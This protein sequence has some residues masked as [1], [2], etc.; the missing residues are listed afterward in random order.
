MTDAT[1]PAITND[2]PDPDHDPSATRPNPPTPARRFTPARVIALALIA[3]LVCGLTYVWASSGPDRLSVPAHAKAGDLA[4]HA[5]QYDTEDGSAAADCGTLVVPENRNDPHSR[6]IAVP[7]TRIRAR[8]PSPG[9]PIF[10]LQGGPGLTNM[11]FAEAS[12][13]DDHHDVVLV[14]YR[15]VDGSSVLDCP[16]VTSA[17][18]HS[19]DFLATSS[20][21]AYAD[22]FRA[23]SNRL[24]RGGVDLA[25]Y[26]VPER[27]DDLEAARV[28]LGYGRIDL[29][30]ESAGTRTAMVYSWRHPDSINRS[31]M[32]GANPPGNFLWNPSA[33]DEQLARYADVCAKD[34][35]CRNRTSDLTASAQQAMSSIPDRWG[36]FPIK[37]GNV[38]IAS[39]YG[40]FDASSN[41]SPIAAPMTI[42][43]WLSALKGDPSGYWMSSLAADVT[44]PN[45]FVWGDLAAISRA[46]ASAAAERFSTHQDAGVLG[47]PGTRF[48]WA[49]G[50][51]V[52]AWPAG[53]DDNAYS[54][55]TTSSTETLVIGGELDAT[56]PPQIATRELMPH[57][58]NGHQ[59][60]LKGFG[61]TT[62]FWT[63][64]TAAGSRL[65]NTFFDTGRVDDS[66]YQP[67]IVDFRPGM[68]QSAIAKIVAGSL[69]AMAA[70]TLL[71]LAVMAWRV[72][73][74]GRFGRKAGAVVRSVWAAA[75][76]LGGWVIGVLVGGDPLARPADRRPAARGPLGRAAR[77]PRR[78][79]RV[80]PPGLD[81]S[82]APHRLGRRHGRLVGRCLA[83]LPRHV[84]GG[85]HRDRHGRGRRRR[86]P[87]PDP[88]R[89]GPGRSGA[90]GLG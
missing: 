36:V 78:L 10:R 39:F 69:A 75:L 11:T 38:Q 53:P 15:G 18:K 76:G 31:V 21:Q 65:V 74:K 19:T 84:P 49:G 35:S 51:L 45:A 5:C 16:E 23:C 32:V 81:G 44:F 29:L 50:R 64:Q 67:G 89:H 37:R 26:S 40:L 22:A 82:H 41:A 70:F 55:V 43:S 62:D 73:R 2:N 13:Y 6:L 25:G 7:V 24:Q 20:Q 27:V 60:V 3:A 12:R 30:S 46:D 57:L 66:L 14:G 28:A 9:E 63:Q 56:T 85:R 33:T 42:D 52:D 87:R 58:P 34:T 47:D 59:V 79:V 54:H 77:R 48:I 90:V 8:S 83:R 72:H 1:P 68:T 86:Q 88:V 61:H 4:L 80:G 71:S 17:L